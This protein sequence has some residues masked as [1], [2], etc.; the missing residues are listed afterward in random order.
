MNTSSSPR[1]ALIHA[2]AHSVTPVNTA[3]IGL[4]P[5]AIRMNLLDDSLSNDLAATEAKAP[6]TGL[7]AFMHE[8]F[9]RLTQYAVDCGS[10]AILFTCS[11]F[12]SCIEAAA[13]TQTIPVL[14]PN[15]AMIEQAVALVGEGGTMPGQSLGLVSSFAPTLVSMPPEFPKNIDLRTKLAEGAMAALNAGGAENIAKH[16]VLVVAAAQELV[17]GGAKVIALAQYSM[18]HC[19]PLVEA[20]LGVPVLTTP[21]SAIKKLKRLLA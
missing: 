10:D 2:L 9:A 3:M 14:K 19:K 15:E 18:A 1:I 20:A 21:D 5:E 4:W 11:A 17:A 7:D 12:G 16:D 8:R 13:S 6:G